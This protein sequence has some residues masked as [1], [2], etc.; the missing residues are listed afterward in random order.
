M[1]RTKMILMTA[2]L[3][4]L[5]VFMIMSARAELAPEYTF[6]DPYV[7]DS[8]SV[9]NDGAVYT[10]ETPM[11]DAATVSPSVEL[12]APVA[13]AMPAMERAAVVPTVANRAA[14]SR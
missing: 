8:G 1:T 6:G 9:A 5:P 7:S 2:A 10:D 11:T 14:A 12:N 3:M 4:V 13:P